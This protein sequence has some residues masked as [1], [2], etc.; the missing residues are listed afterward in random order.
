MPRSRTLPPMITLAEDLWPGR[1]SVRPALA[2][3][4]RR[5]EPRPEAAVDPVSDTPIAQEKRAA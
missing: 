4:P 2:L 3:V 1:T 5:Q